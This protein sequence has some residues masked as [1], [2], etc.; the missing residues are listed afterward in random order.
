MLHFFCQN[1][2]VLAF[3]P[4][5]GAKKW[6]APT[7]NDRFGFILLKLLPKRQSRLGAGHMFAFRLGEKAKYGHPAKAGR[8]TIA[9]T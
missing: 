6:L 8:A 9:F 3:S 4:R 2:A 1:A 5:R 7:R